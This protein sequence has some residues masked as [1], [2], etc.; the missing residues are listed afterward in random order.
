MNLDKTGL[1]LFTILAL[2]IAYIEYE[3]VKF[4]NTEL[5]TKTVLDI[6][7]KTF[8][9]FNKKHDINKNLNRYWGLAEEVAI[10]E[11][12]IDDNNTIQ[13]TQPNGK[14]VL[15]INKSC[16]RLLGI[17]HNETISIVTMYN[18]DLKE[19]VK[20]YTTKEI[21]ESKIFIDKITHDTVEF[22]DLTT[23]QRWNFKIFDVNQ[24]RYKPKEIKE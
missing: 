19:K 11:T 2:L 15:C 3:P 13:I 6:D 21:L 10:K 4:N 17:H 9:M 23:S 8:E 16:Y 24:T 12:I 18:Q 7:I 14:N 5:P 1:T 20:N 22:V